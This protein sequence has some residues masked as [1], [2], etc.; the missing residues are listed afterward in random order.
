MVF[1]RTLTII[2]VTI[3]WYATS[4]TAQAGELYGLNEG[5]G[6]L[7]VIGTGRLPVEVRHP[8]QARLLAERAAIVDAYGTAARL[9]AKAIPQAAAEPNDYSVFFRGGIVRRS[10]VASDGSVTVELE[11]PMRPELIGNVREIMQDEERLEG[12][13]AERVGIGHAQFV[14]RHRVKGPRVITHREWT[15]RYR[16]GTWMPYNR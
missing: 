8:A 5:T 12:R 11:I 16:T 2:A 9:L 10:A 4:A 6:T 3:I 15:E 7:S 14:A 1:F 13:V